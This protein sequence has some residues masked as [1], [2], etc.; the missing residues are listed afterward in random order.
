MAATPTRIPVRDIT[1]TKPRRRLQQ[2][3]NAIQAQPEVTTPSAVYIS[4]A[5]RM[6]PGNAMGRMGRGPLRGGSA[7]PA[8]F[9]NPPRIAPAAGNSF[10]TVD[11]RGNTQ[12]SGIRATSNMG[13]P[14]KWGTDLGPGNASPFGSIPGHQIRSVRTRRDLDG[15]G[16]FAYTDN[17]QHGALIAHDRHIIANQGRTTSSRDYQRTGANPNPEKDGPPRPAWKMF[18][19]TIS[20]QIGISDTRQLNNAGYHASVIA[21]TG[22]EKQQTFSRWSMVV[23]NASQG[24]KF[25]LGKQ[26]DEW[27][28]R[29]GGTPGLANYRPYG[30]RGGYN[31]SAPMPTVRADPGGP[32]RFNTLIQVGAPEDGPQKVY[33]GVAWGLHSPTLPPRQGSQSLIRSRLGQVKPVWNVR[34]LNSKHAGQ[35]WSQSMVSLSGQQAVKI[36]STPPIRQPGLNSRWLGT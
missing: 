23:N 27:T 28:L 25:P 12:T 1:A 24:Q 2:K 26:G 5:T 11:A 7:D 35:S 31:S 10:V 3:V 13:G 15:A 6:V 22:P 34:P 18:N 4:A 9:S 16:R 17:F 14:G 36:A 20:H 32:Y 30:T 33:G 8:L 21:Q 29:Y 19:R